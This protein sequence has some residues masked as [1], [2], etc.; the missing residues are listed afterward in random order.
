LIAWQG[1]LLARL[2]KQCQTLPFHKISTLKMVF[3]DEKTIPLQAKYWLI[4][5][6]CILTVTTLIWIRKT[7]GREDNQLE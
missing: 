3:K 4:E 1:T 2:K 6:T 7:V 5:T